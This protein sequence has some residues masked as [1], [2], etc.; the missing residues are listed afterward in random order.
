[1]AKDRDRDG[2]DT[3]AHGQSKRPAMG[4]HRDTN[5]SQHSEHNAPQQQANPPNHQ[6][7]RQKS[8]QKYVVGG[9][10]SRLHGRVPSSKALTRHHA[11]APSAK[12]AVRRQS[13]PSPDPAEHAFPPTAAAAAGPSGSSS[14]H[15]RA[16]S[17]L[18]L[19][20]HHASSS[21]NLKKNLS[22]TSLKRNRSHADVAKRNGSGGGP[23]GGGGSRSSGGVPLKRS[24]SNPTVAKKAA[25]NQ[26]HF[27][28]GTGDDDED[29]GD[30]WVDASSSAS[31]YISR[32]GSVVSSGHPESKPDSPSHH[33]HHHQHQHHHHGQQ[34]QSPC[35][36]PHPSQ[37]PQLHHPT[38]DTDVSAENSPRTRTQLSPSR[39]HSRGHSQQGSL[40]PPSKLLQRV[41]SQTAVPM[42]STES[43]TGESASAAAHRL[44]QRTSAPA[45]SPDSNASAFSTETG[46]AAPRRRGMAGSSGGGGGDIT[47]RFVT[48][49]SHD[50]SG[51]P[52]AGGSFYTPSS[53]MARQ[54]DENSSLPDRTRSLAAMN[55]AQKSTAL[56]N[57]HRRGGEP[58]SLTSEEEA[59]SVMGTSAAGSASS[60]AR[61]SM[62]YMAQPAEKSRT[63]QKLNL[64]R[65]SSTLEPNPHH[66][67]HH[68]GPAASP[69]VGGAGYDT[70]DPRVGKLLDR[71]GMEYMVVRRY[72]NPVARSLVR[73]SHIPGADKSRRIPLPNGGGPGH[74]KRH[75]DYAAVGAASRL[76]QSY[77][78]QGTSRPGSSAAAVGGISTKPG[79]PRRAWSSIRA[80]GANSSAE[81]DDGGVRRLHGGGEGL[82]GASLVD[83]E[84]DDG[85]L[86]LLR[87]MWEKN[88]DLS[89][90]QE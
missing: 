21:T 17:E 77:R 80:N 69:L 68:Q 41:P 37:Q 71:A 22:A 1:M 70:R 15:R 82:S 39:A 72:Q 64:Q 57:G 48:T 18:R 65:A 74:A 58:S 34:Q 4:A 33:H 51:N 59:N 8:Q 63:Q 40:P 49:S 60:R 20:G 52:A 30:E 38:F 6:Q 76:S 32:R 13:S 9:G 79:P 26:V 75:S 87:N 61:L 50:S 36:N 14:H 62:P 19:F 31:P 2:T 90:S 78:E 89:A 81:T 43:A 7:H 35:Q 23:G 47:S 88:M 46:L 85:T 86:A 11:A 25:K 56:Q 84:E 55:E 54:H 67:P 5:D 66:L 28:L 12:P 29:D 3:S 73:L 16:S 10:T 24:L 83:G 42:M 53:R 27:A 44:Q 45:A